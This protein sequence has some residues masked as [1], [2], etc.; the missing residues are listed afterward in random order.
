MEDSDV[1]ILRFME[2]ENKRLN[3]IKGLCE[4][5]APIMWLQ[6]RHKTC[7]KLV[8]KQHSLDSCFSLTDV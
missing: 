1:I 7:E 2:E 6:R 4:P 8:K 3:E 5:G